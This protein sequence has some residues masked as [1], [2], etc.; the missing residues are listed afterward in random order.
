MV[1]PGA[2]RTPISWALGLAQSPMALMFWLPSRSIWEA[3]MIR[4]R[5]PDHTTSKTLR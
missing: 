5:R 4:L 1:L 3:I 2:P